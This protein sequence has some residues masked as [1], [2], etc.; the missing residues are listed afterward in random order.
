M[1]SYNVS[2]IFFT[3]QAQRTKKNKQ[4]IKCLEKANSS[5]SVQESDCELR[6]KG[7]SLFSTMEDTTVDANGV[8]NLLN[9]L[10]VHKVYGRNAAGWPEC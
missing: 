6:S 4:K 5:W 2:F 8:A 7:T 9:K 10:N 1:D 3:L